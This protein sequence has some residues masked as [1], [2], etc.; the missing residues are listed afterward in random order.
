MV[1]M[2]RDAKTYT[3]PACERP[4][5]AAITRHKTLGVF[6]PVWGPGPCHNRDCP[7]YVPRPHHTPESHAQ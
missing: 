7:D 4:V 3:C 5:E 2:E 6:V 1:K